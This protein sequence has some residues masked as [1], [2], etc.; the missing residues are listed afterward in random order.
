[1]EIQTETGLQ[2]AANGGS[3]ITVD[4]AVSIAERGA[5]RGPATGSI[6]V[7]HTVKRK[8]VIYEVLETPKGYCTKRCKDQRFGCKG[9]QPCGKSRCGTCKHINDR[10]EVTSSTTGY[11]IKLKF[12]CTCET[13]NVV[14]MLSCVKCGMQYIGETKRSL[15]QRFGEHKNSVKKNNLNT[16]LVK[17]FNQIGHTYDDMSILVLHVIEENQDGKYRHTQCEDYYIRLFNTAYPFGL[18]DKIK[19]YGCATEISN[20][21]LYK[22]QPYFCNKFKRKNRGRGAKCNK[23][24]TRKNESFIDEIQQI[25]RTHQNSDGVL[26]VVVYLRKQNLK[27]LR[28]H[29][30]EIGNTGSRLNGNLQLL[31]LGYMC[32]YYQRFVNKKVTNSNSI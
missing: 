4:P 20:P 6:S 8:K 21:T 25:Y 31:L 19:G 23:R 24:R 27:T 13:K 18:N 15:R 10:K 26:S 7:N 22:T 9:T 3:E 32:G 29:F 12:D 1:M 16:V 28:Y 2:S 11:G 5:S 30:R 17:H 14:Y